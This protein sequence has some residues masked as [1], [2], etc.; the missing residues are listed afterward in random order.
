MV[1]VSVD[2]GTA[3]CSYSV[4]TMDPDVVSMPVV[5]AAPRK[6]QQMPSSRGS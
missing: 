1:E 2:E 3:C 4:S 5:Y 6:P